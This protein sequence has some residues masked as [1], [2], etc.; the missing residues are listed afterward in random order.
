M[1]IIKEYNDLKNR[2]DNISSLVYGLQMLNECDG[3]VDEIIL[4]NVIKDDV[5]DLINNPNEIFDTLSVIPYFLPE[6]I[7]NF[8]NTP[9]Y[10]E[11]KVEYKIDRNKWL[12]NYRLLSNGIVSEENKEFTKQWLNELDELYTLLNKEYKE[13]NNMGNIN[14]L[15]QSILELGWNPE[16][17]F[18]MV[19]RNKVRDIMVNKLKNKYNKDIYDMSGFMDNIDD[20]IV[21]ESADIEKKY[22]LFIVL[23]YVASGAARLITRFTKGIY[24]HAAIS[25]E[26]DLN[27][28]YSYNVM[29]NGFAIESIDRYLNIDPNSNMAVYTILLNKDDLLK[30]KTKLDYFLLNKKNTKYSVLNILGVMINKPVELANDMICSQFVD[31]ILKTVDIDITHKHSGLVTPN[32]LY[33]AMNPSVYKIFEGKMVDYDK[34]KVDRL[35]NSLIK[36]SISS[37]GIDISAPLKPLFVKEAKE[38][39][40]QFDN[41]GNLLIKRMK[42]LDIDHEYFKSHKLLLVYEDTNN[43]EGM[44]YELSKLWFLNNLLEKKLYSEKDETIRNNYHKSRSRI[45]NDFNKYLKIV[46]SEENT[47]IFGDYYN[48]SPFSD[49]TIKINSSTL[50]HGG[51]LLKNMSKLLMY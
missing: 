7:D 23:T 38:F 36:K 20:C 31:Y 28:I 18:N 37:K 11:V 43:I 22:P 47:F 45:L 10:S 44:K 6:E 46:T 13:N 19:T 4:S 15:K 40:V 16:L 29:D 34:K 35:V 21:S 48:N 51:K 5:E 8:R 25:L 39:P 9:V 14:S 42:Y 3:I 27:R 49:A 41:D 26:S 2:E 1:N 17:D 30:V 12:D 32:D 24:S 50:H 33:I